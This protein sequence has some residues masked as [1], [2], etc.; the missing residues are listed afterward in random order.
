MTQSSDDQERWKN[1]MKGGL[2]AYEVPGDHM[3]V[4][5]EHTAAWAERLKFCISKAQTLLIFCYIADFSHKLS[6]I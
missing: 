3:E 5:R 6:V 4:I 1:L 2:E